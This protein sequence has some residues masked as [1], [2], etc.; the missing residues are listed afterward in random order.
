MSDCRYFDC[1]EAFSKIDDFLDRELSPE[2]MVLV[3]LHLE[4]CE[5]CAT[6]F[7]FEGSVLKELRAKL[8]HI[9]L[10]ADLLQRLSKALDDA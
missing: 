1:K 10:P 3:R 4:K 7:V 8:A 6:E 2:E 9:D 5:M